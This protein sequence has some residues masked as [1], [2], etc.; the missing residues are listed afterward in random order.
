MI[1]IGQDAA[2][3]EPA[4]VVGWTWHRKKPVGGVI[5]ACWSKAGLD[6]ARGVVPAG[7][8]HLVM[9]HCCCCCCCS[10]RLLHQV[11]LHDV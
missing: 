8:L 11:A 6:E 1:A 3:G 4:D 10:A 9:C 5:A 7:T 2:E